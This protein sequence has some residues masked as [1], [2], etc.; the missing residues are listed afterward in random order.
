MKPV[1]AVATRYCFMMNR[2][3]RVMAT[4]S[5]RVRPGDPLPEPVAHAGAVLHH[6]E[7][8]EQQE[9]DAA[10]DLARQPGL[11]G[12]LLGHTTRRLAH[13]LAEVGLQLVDL[14]PGPVEGIALGPLLGVVDGHVDLAAEVAEL[15]GD[16]GADPHQGSHHDPQ[17]AEEDGGRGEGRRPAVPAQAGRQRFEHRGQ[18]QGQH[19]RHHHHVQLDQDQD[20]QAAAAATTRMRHPQAAAP[21]ST[22]GTLTGGS[23]VAWTALVV[24]GR[25]H[26]GGGVPG[27]ARRLFGDAA[28][29]Q[30]RYQGRHPGGAGGASRGA[31]VPSSNHCRTAS[32]AASP[33]AGDVDLAMLFVTSAPTW[34][35]GSPRSRPPSSRRRPVG[36]VAEEVV[37]RGHRPHR[38]RP[39]GGVPAARAG[40][41]PRCAPSPTSG[42]A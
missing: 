38:G 2:A 35:S 23:R 7:Q 25:Q 34:P 24:H 40:W 29:P 41:T 21:S 13:R 39:A 28:A 36:G 6:E 4:A 19:H 42:R 9:H 10:Q 20:E 31:S 27:T 33:G 37:R 18:E 12:G 15:G 8:G 26:Y 14:L 22:R 5:S 3:W 1:A 11:T 17:E 30:A 32:I 16:A